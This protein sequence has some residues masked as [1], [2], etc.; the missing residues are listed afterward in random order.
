MTTTTITKLLGETGPADRSGET[1]HVG[2]RVDVLTPV[3]GLCPIGCRVT[4][5]FPTDCF[6]SVAVIDERGQATLV[7]ASNV[8]VSR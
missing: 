6:P 2:A 5:T 3:R 8:R 4:R 1:I 7:N